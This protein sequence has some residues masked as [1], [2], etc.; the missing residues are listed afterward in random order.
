MNMNNKF[1]VNELREVKDR[2][3]DMSTRYHNALNENQDL[4]KRFTN[5]VSN[6]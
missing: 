5:S 6:Y 2:L 1:K 3:T 4:K